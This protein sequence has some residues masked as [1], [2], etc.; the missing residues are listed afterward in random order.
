MGL[1]SEFDAAV[2]E[3]R[4]INFVATEGCDI[5]IFEATIRHM[6]GMLAAFD[7]SGGQKK[8]DILVEKAVEL[9]EVLYTAFD[10]SNRM[11]LP[12]LNWSA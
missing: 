2:E 8:Y 4:N 1:Y 12:H 9:A 10:T 3:I 11:P 5:D 6:G 7:I